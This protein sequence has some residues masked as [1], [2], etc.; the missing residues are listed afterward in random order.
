M[1]MPEA[2]RP[3]MN[4]NFIL[5]KR[6]ISEAPRFVEIV[7]EL[8]GDE[9]IFNHLVAFHPTLADEGLSGFK[10]LANE[11][12][13]ATRETAARLG[14]KLKIPPNFVLD[15][16]PPSSPPAK[17]S[18]GRP[19]ARP[20]GPP[21]IKCWF[22]WKRVYIGVNGEVVPCCLA[23][24]PHFGS[25]MDQ[26]FRTIWNGDTYQTYRR[27]V[28]TSEPFGQCKNCYLIYPSPDQTEAEGFL[29]Y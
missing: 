19:A 27:Q 12:M 24:M 22:L 16:P 14:V 29:K 5:M 13:D 3:R 11:H 26:G 17:G 20:C 18:A 23:G 7:S 8:G 1:E 10:E 21:P 15:G 4:F 9:I 6:T 28:F 25:M 2:E